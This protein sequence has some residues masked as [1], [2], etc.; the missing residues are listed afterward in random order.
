MSLTPEYEMYLNVKNGQVTFEEFMAWLAR[1]KT[2]SESRGYAAGSENAYR[3]G[4][5]FEF[6]LQLLQSINNSFVYFNQ[7]S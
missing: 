1:E 3:N 5:G 6:Q 2:N 4:G 7:V